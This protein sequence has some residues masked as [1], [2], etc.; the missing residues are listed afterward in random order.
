[1][2]NNLRHIA[3]LILFICSASSV[4]AQTKT[5]SID[6]AI[7]AL[8]KD[9]SLKNAS[10]S[11]VVKD[12]D[13]SVIISEYNPNLSL[14]SASTMKVV[15]TA[16]AL[17]ILGSYMKF[18]TKIMYDG[19]IDSNNVLNGN[20]YIKGGGDPTLGSKYFKEKYGLF[21]STWVDEIAKLGIDSITGSVIGD[22][23]LFSDEYVASTWSWSDIGNYYGAG[24]SGLT[25]YDNTVKFEFSS[26]P[27][28]HDST[29]VDCF[30]PYTP[31]LMIDNKVKASNTKKDLAY[32]Y[33]G[34]NN[35][36]RTIKGTIPKG[37][38]EYVVKGSIHEPAYVAAFELETALWEYGIS[39]G[40]NAT[41]I[42]RMKSLGNYFESDRKGVFITKSPTVSQIVYWTNL[43]SNNLYAEHLLKHIGVKKYG[44]GSVFSSTLAVTKYWGSKGI[45]MAGFYMNDGSGLSR[46]NAITASQLVGV[47][48]YMKLKS[49]Y[50]KSFLSSLP[51]A[52]KTGTLRSIGKKTKIAGNLQAKSGTMTRIKSY[53]GYVKSASGR[54]LAF[55]IVINNHNCTSFEIKK[56]L[57][58]VMIALG[59][60]N[61]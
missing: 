22:A 49:K 35:P 31:D 55:A 27:S 59:N 7:S 38:I 1:V 44:D 46:S 15:S 45:D 36:T 39:V 16:A 18:E 37:Q 23:S 53:A 47:L 25:I 20:I 40:G 54:N 13:S 8:A 19:Y 29:F 9:A 52:G 50:S 17:D 10:I 26:G 43:I 51:V 28:A 2:K 48:A 33:G 42:R 57:E 3:L 11:F 32:I 21:L 60:Y 12:L 14:P 34:P 30:Y 41:T 6:V 56:K 58:V 24:V 61:D 4:R 5:N